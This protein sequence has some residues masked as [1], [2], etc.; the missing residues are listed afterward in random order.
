MQT[1]KAEANKNS[2]NYE[3]KKLEKFYAEYKNRILYTDQEKTLQIFKDRISL[4]NELEI[5]LARL[6]KF[7]PKRKEI[8]E[9]YK[10]Y[11]DTAKEVD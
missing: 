7:D 2:E 3:N 9:D 1:K 11:L 6:E 5:K 8:I 10:N 4:L